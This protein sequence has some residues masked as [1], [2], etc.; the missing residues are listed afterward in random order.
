MQIFSIWHIHFAAIPNILK[1]SCLGTLPKRSYMCLLHIKQVILNVAIDAWN[2]KF[3]LYNIL[4]SNGN[5][6]VHEF[7]SVF[8]F[9]RSS[10]I[11]ELNIRVRIQYMQPLIQVVLIRA[12]I[13]EIKS[14]KSLKYVFSYYNFPPQGKTQVL[15]F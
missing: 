12:D 10:S 14:F 1:C 2:M 11:P 5:S 15:K 3:Y 9:S 8:F 13:Q 6:K 7:N 4:L